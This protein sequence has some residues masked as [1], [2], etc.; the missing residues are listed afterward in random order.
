M[1]ISFLRI[2]MIIHE[3]IRLELC[4][5]ILLEYVAQFKVA[6]PSNLLK[7]IKGLHKTK[8]ITAC[9]KM[10]TMWLLHIDLLPKCF[11]NVE[12]WKILK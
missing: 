6:H 4:K 5:F 7:L 8:H 9:S 3:R 12:A 11:S 10:E 1:V 2:D